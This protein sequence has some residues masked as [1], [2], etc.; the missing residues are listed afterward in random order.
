[1]F[2]DLYWLKTRVSGMLTRFTG[3]LV[4][5]GMGQLTGAFGSS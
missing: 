3:L 2:L 4:H 1:M 5:G